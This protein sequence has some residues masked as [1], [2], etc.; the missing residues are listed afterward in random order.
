M[1]REVNGARWT[2]KRAYFDQRV[3]EAESDMRA[4]WEVL[5]EVIGRSKGKNGWVPCGY[6]RKDGVGSPQ[7]DFQLPASKIF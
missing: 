6:F 7:E 4:S 3:R 2:L 1:Q 5:R